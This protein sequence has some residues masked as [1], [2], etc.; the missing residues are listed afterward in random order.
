MPRFLSIEGLDFEI[1]SGVLTDTSL[2]IEERN[3]Q[4]YDAMSKLK[5]EY[6]EILYLLYFNELTY[7]EAAS[8]MGKSEKQITNLSYQGRRSLKNILQGEGFV[9]ADK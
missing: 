2:D 4:L 8:V 3:R 5:A 7:A 9:Y 6:R 1:P